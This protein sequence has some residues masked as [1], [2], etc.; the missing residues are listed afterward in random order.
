MKSPT[1]TCSS[2]GR[3]RTA[4]KG[5]TLCC[6]SSESFSHPLQQGEALVWGIHRAWGPRAGWSWCLLV[7]KEGSQGL[8]ARTDW[9]RMR[10]WEMGSCQS[11]GWRQPGNTARFWEKQDRKTWQKGQKR[12]LE[13]PVEERRTK[14][15]WERWDKNQNR[16]NLT[17][18]Q[19]N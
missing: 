3:G 5:L 2:D 14:N 10:S 16:K 7:M 9:S 15:Y 1:K 18:S 12:H 8:R 17:Q 19:T 6:S 11:G 4:W 13:L